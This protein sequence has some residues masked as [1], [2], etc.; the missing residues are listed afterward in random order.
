MILKVST[1]IIVILT[2]FVASI[3]AQTATYLGNEGILIEYQNSKI[4][5]DA[6]FEDPSGRFENLDPESINKVINGKAPYDSIDLMLVT[7]SHADHFNPSYTVE[8][9]TKNPETRLIASPQVLDSMRNV[10][11][12]IDTLNDRINIYPWVRGWKNVSIENI[13]V[14]STYTRHGGKAHSK[15][16]NQIFLITIGDKKILHIG[17]T[18]MDVSNFDKLKLIYEEIDVAFVPFWFMTSLYGSEI[19]HKHISAKQ[20]VGVH[21]PVKKNEKTLSKIKAAFPDS[22]VF[23]VIGEKISF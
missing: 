11:D 13:K 19:V 23:Q 14:M 20:I 12:A 18:Q 1:L 15:T 10:S 6:L 21:M 8:M 3:Y 9:L 4:L 2:G 22:K 17:D 16:Q 7:H 5:I